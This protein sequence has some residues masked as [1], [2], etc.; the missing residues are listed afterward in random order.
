MLVPKEG[1]FTPLTVSLFLGA[2]SLW[3][4]IYLWTSKLPITW[5]LRVYPPLSP[6]RLVVTLRGNYNKLPKRMMLNFSNLR[7]R[8]TVSGFRQ[9][10]MELP[11][12]AFTHPWHYLMLYG[13]TSKHRFTSLDAFFTSLS[14]RPAYDICLWRNHPPLSACPKIYKRHL[15]PHWMN[16]VFVQINPAN[17]N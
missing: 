6:S 9:F 15:F 5:R 11:R 14:T 16:K 13:V 4:K 10:I 2:L 8:N 7:F 1:K 3:C 12:L 17:S